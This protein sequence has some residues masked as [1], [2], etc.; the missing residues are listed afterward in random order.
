[1]DSQKHLRPL[2]F[3]GQAQRV[4]LEVGQTKRARI[5][6][7]LANRETV[8]LLRCPESPSHRDLAPFCRRNSQNRKR[9]HHRARDRLPRLHQL[10]LRRDLSATKVSTTFTLKTTQL[11]KK[12]KK[13]GGMS[14][15]VAYIC[16]PSTGEAEAGDLCE[17]EAS[18]V[19]GVSSR[20]ATAT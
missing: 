4:E 14:T 18:L 15:V 9:N 2:R 11:S 8:L 6:G 19:Y 1:M 12:K 10:A 7:R 17:F 3:L 5:L 13:G 20:T 16:H